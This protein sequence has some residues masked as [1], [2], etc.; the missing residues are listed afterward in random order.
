MAWIAALIGAAG[1]YMSAQSAKKS[2]SKLGARQDQLY[3]IQAETARQ[4]QPFAK[5]FYEKA[6]DAYNPAA[7]YYRAVAGNDR[8][9]IMGALAPE[10]SSIGRRYGSLITASRDL[11]PR[12]G[13]SAAYNTDLAFRAGDEQQ[14]LINNE[15]QSAY[16]NLA[17]LAGTA[18]D[19]GAGAAGIATN[20][21]AGAA[22]ILNSSAALQMALAR[23]QGEA[24]GQIGEAISKMFG[25][26]STTGAWY[27]GNQP[28]RG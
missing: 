7:A 8:S 1:S 17:K 3:G 15:R 22:G 4:L 2:A 14:A 27:L 28:G 13:A 23:N 26:D 6:E 21:G 10:L 24:Y 11:N 12:S 18:G 19:L 9:R 5:S 20:A 25:R 16:G